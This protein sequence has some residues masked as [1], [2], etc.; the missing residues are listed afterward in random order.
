M[1]FLRFS[2]FEYD[3]TTLS[4]LGYMICHF[5]NLGN[6]TKKNGSDLKLNTVSTLDGSHQLSISSEYGETLSDTIQICKNP[7]LNTFHDIEITNNELRM[8]TR[9][10]NRKEYH[11]LRLLE[12][13]SFDAYVMA[14]FNV[15]KIEVSGVLCG[16]ELTP[17]IESAFT[18][19]EDVTYKIHADTNNY[20]KRI[21]DI[22]EEEGFIYPKMTIEMKASGDLN[23]HNSIENRDMLIKN[24]QNGEIII[25]EY[26]IISSSISSHAIQNDFNW[27]F[28]RI[29]NT[30]SQQ[31]NDITISLPCEITMTYTPIA[32]IT[33]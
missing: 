4:D 17:I 29:A 2:D 31:V 1:R 25:L 9:W 20:V 30:F 27:N 28:F 19:Q 6:E 13:K 24:C 32:K 33:M 8:M 10:L 3:G 11:K 14:T 7:C 18:Y 16:L 26:P 15:S 5:D 23:I 21:Y 22:S 12:E